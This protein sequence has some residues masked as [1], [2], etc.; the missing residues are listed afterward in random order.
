MVRYGYAALQ[1]IAMLMYPIT[2]FLPTHRPRNDDRQYASFN[3]KRNLSKS[4][5]DFIGLYWMHNY[6]KCSS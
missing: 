5:S 1:Y 6:M 4:K 3:F 2:K